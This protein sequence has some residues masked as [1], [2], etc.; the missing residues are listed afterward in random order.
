MWGS[1]KQGSVTLSTVEAEYVSLADDLKEVL[2]VKGILTVENQG[3]M[4]LAENKGTSKHS[5][6][7]D[8][9]HHFVRELVEKGEIDLKYVKSSDNIADILTKPLNGPKTKLLT[10]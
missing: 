2:W 4:S 6:H 1:R 9:R 8:V 3:A 5:K 10:K 7:I